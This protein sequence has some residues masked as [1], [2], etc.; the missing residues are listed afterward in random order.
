MIGIKKGKASLNRPTPV[1]PRG[2][3]GFMQNRLK[4]MEEMKKRRGNARQAGNSQSFGE[5]TQRSE[6]LNTLR[7]LKTGSFPFMKRK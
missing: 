4:M 1:E 7:S 2:V 5:P 6:M 3:A